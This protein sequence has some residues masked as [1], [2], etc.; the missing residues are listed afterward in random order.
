M[1]LAGGIT[2]TF[3]IRLEDQKAP[4]AVANFIG[5]ATGRKG[6]IDQNTGSIRNDPYYNGVIFHR[7]IANFIS[8]TGSRSGDET[9]GPGYTFHNEID[10]SLTH[11][12]PYTIAMANSG[13]AYSNGAQWYV[14]A[15]SSQ[16][17]LDGNYTIFGTVISGTAVCDALN[18]VPTSG[19]GGSPRDRPISPITISSISFHGPSLASFNLK[20]DALPKVL[21]A[22]PVMKVSGTSYSLGYD[23]NSY[24]YYYGYDSSD[25]IHWTQT[26]SSY[27]HAL[28]PAAGDVDVTT[29]CKGSKHFFKQSRV[30]Y[31]LCYNPNVL[32]SLAGKVIRFDSVAGYILTGYLYVDASNTATWY[33]ESI[34]P[35]T[36][37]YYNYTVFPYWSNPVIQFQNGVVIAIDHLEPGSSIGGTFSG[38]IITS[39]TSSLS[40]S[41]SILQ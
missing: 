8:Q 7:V 15:N 26:I 16:S 30:D 22:H 29:L 2:G 12:T 19:A 34:T 1:T 28:P 27:M 3:T 38:R 13:G 11:A 31:G 25:L 39:S 41:Y 10:A 24:S 40:G 23:H 32:S 14:T 4:A 9:D 6:W 37:T 20:P 35:Y 18:N 33:D 36:L 17:F 21:S 5:L